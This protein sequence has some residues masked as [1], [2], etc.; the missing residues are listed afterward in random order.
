M[1]AKVFC[2]GFHKTGTTSLNRALTELGYRVRSTTGITN[3]SI[4]TDVEQIARPLVEKYDAFEDNPWPILFDKLDKWAPNSKFILSHRDPDEWYKS[5]L[6][7]FGRDT[8][9]MREW[10]YGAGHGAPEGK[11]AIYK[12]RYEQHY[13]TVRAYF[14]DRPEDLLELSLKTEFRWEPICEFLG[15]PIPRV[16]FPVANQAADR[17]RRGQLHRK[18]ARSLKRVVLGT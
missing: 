1:K 9:P 6:R 14:K 8:T 15:Q 18:I 3:K 7:H 16:P 2:I 10:I 5:I 11:E 4:A 17:E 13:Q 12:A